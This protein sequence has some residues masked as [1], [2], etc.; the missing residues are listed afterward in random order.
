MARTSLTPQIPTRAGLAVTFAAANTDGHSF[1]NN[2]RM[3][4][5]LKNTNAAA[6]TVTVR[7]GGSVDGTAITGGKDIIVP[8]LTGDMTTAVY[9]KG[10]YDQP[11][12]T[13]WL[14]YS[15][16][17]DLTVAVLSV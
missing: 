11:D 2:G 5:R 12:G 14:D 10:D 17:A 4:L 15:A 7:F 3:I 6:R 1:A 9:P 13:V 16:T 8:A